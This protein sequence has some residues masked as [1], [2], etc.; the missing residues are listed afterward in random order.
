MEQHRND[1]DERL[2]GPEQQSVRNLVATLPDEEPSMAWRSQL[3]ER[4]RALPAQARR[5]WWEL[6][7]KPTVGLALAGG[8]AV[9]VFVKPTP[10]PTLESTPS[11]SVADAM[12]TICSVYLATFAMMSPFGAGLTTT[13]QPSG[14]VVATQAARE[15]QTYHEREL[16]TPAR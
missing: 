8:L 10:A 14:N 9:L 15:R 1:W 13:P 7:W 3:N 6:A 12:I 16:Y 11:V 5:K 2:E 4:L